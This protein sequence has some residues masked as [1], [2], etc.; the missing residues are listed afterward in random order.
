MKITSRFDGL[1]MKELPLPGSASAAASATPQQALGGISPLAGHAASPSQN[2]IARVLALEQAQRD[3][4]ES[5]AAAATRDQ[6]MGDGPAPMELDGV[7]PR[8]LANG[9]AG[10]A[11]PA[12]ATSAAAAVAAAAAGFAPSP[13]PAVAASPSG[14]GAGV[15]VAAG[16]IGPPLSPSALHSAV[17]GSQL[18]SLALGGG[19]A[20]AAALGEV[21]KASARVSIK[22]FLNVTAAKN[23]QTLHAIACQRQTQ[24]R[25]AQQNRTGGRRPFFFS[26]AHVVVV[27]VLLRLSLCCRHRDRRR[28]RGVSQTQEQTR[29]DHILSAA[30]SGLSGAR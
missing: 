17:D 6:T 1:R 23:V 10:I 8:Q 13:L 11:A 16:T 21:V 4:A 29:N 20:G 18:S 3:H 14:A 15:G 19:G 12:A 28:I 9:T 25:K 30:H 5:A 22:K 27:L 26:L 24:H 7:S 2:Q